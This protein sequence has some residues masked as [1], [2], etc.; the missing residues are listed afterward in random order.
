LSRV[1][2]GKAGEGRIPWEVIAAN[3]WSKPVRVEQP[4]EQ[5]LLPFLNNI[6]TYNSGGFAGQN[7]VF[8]RESLRKILFVAKSV[9]NNAIGW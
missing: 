4:I 5:A 1:A 8:F 3:R 9:D 6:L 2:P 7:P